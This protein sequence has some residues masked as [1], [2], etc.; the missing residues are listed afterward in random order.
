MTLLR[1]LK[2]IDVTRGQAG[3]LATQL[4]ADFGAEIVR[5]DEPGATRSPS[6]LVRLRGRRSIAI[7][8]RQP[9]GQR[10]LE[11]LV[12]RADVLISEPGVDG[13]NPIVAPFAALLARNPRLI[14][15]RITGYGE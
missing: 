6:D 13:V 7:D 12:E 8:V 3:P 1:D 4:L 15:C 5:V 9:L 14:L 11:R 2:F 10:L